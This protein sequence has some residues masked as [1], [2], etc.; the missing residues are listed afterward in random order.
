[1]MTDFLEEAKA[2]RYKASYRAFTLVTGSLAL[3]ITFRSSIVAAQPEALW[4]LFAAW[5]ALSIS[6]LSHIIGALAEA[7][8]YFEW[9]QRPP[10]SSKLSRTHLLRI[11]IPS[12][13]TWSGFGTG[14]AFLTVFAVLNNR[15]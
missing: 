5:I 8:V 14:I 11:V 15:A 6:I 7:L 1:M 9:A 12:L 13:F 3:S 2:L 10:T 4:L